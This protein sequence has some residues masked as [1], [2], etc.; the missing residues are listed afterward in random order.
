MKNYLIIMVILLAFISAD[1]QEFGIKFNGFVKTDVILNT[2]KNDEIRDGEMFF[3]PLPKS[4]NI[5]TNEDFN[6]SLNFNMLSFQS[7]LTGN[8][9]APDFLGAKVTGMLETEFFGTSEADI[10]G[11]RLRHAMMKLDWGSEKL[12]IGQ[13]WNPLFFEDAFPKVIAYNTGAP[14]IP[15]ARNPQIRFA[16]NPAKEF[17]INLAAMSQRDFTSSGPQGASNIYLKNNVIPILNLGLRYKT[18]D[19]FI[20]ANA[21]YKSLKPAEYLPNNK[22]NEETI[23]GIVA[24]GVIKISP[25]EDFYA[26]VMGTYGQNSN[27]LFMLGGYSSYNSIVGADTLIKY[28]PWNYFSGMLDLQYGKKL[29]VGLLFGYSMNLGL[30]EKNIGTYKNYMRGENIENLMRI[31][32]RIVYRNGN[33]QFAGEIDYSIATF[34]VY[35][36]SDAKFINTESVNGLRVLLGAYLFF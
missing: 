28:T 32:P 23:S 6:E 21:Q 9:T 34:G 1:A 10:N 35:N 24:N 36:Q 2:R 4:T 22:K 26:T 3:Y 7:R 20:G 27:D 11:M 12:L 33:V 17:E 29:M 31:S 25:S 18:E 19:L 8:I 5:V 13:Y 14:F 16:F 15:F 30:S